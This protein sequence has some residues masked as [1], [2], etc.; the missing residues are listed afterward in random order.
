VTER[1]TTFVT[2]T[3]G[4]GQL[5][6]TQIDEPVRD[7]TWVENGILTVRSSSA[8]VTLPVSNL[9]YFTSDGAPAPWYAVAIT[10][11]ALEYN[12][13]TYV[14]YQNHHEAGDQL[15]TK[16]VALT[17]STG[18]WS[19]GYGITE[20]GV[21]ADSHGVP[22]SAVNADGRLVTAGKGH[23]SN[24]QLDVSTNVEDIR[25]WT[26]PV[27]LTG[28]YAYPHLVL[29][30]DDT[31]L[32]LLR[33]RFLAGTG[34]FTTGAMVLVY[35][36]ITFSGATA[37]PGSEVTVADFGDNSRWY[38]GNCILHDG[39][40]WQ[41]AARSD[42]GDGFRR[43]VYLYAVDTAN[44][45]LVA[46]D[47]TTRSFPVSAADME[48]VFKIHDS[49]DTLTQ[50]IPAMVV[51]D[52]GRWH[53]VYSEGSIG[54]DDIPIYHMYADTFGGA[55]STPAQIGD[56][57]LSA[58][59]DSPTILKSA[60]G[61][62]LYHSN[63]PE[64]V[65]TFA[66]GGNIYRR[67]LAD[68]STTWGDEE[69]VCEMDTTR[70]PLNAPAQVFNSSSAGPRVIW[71]EQALADDTSETAPPKRMY[72]MGDTQ[73]FPKP[74][75]IL[76]GAVTLNGWEF[77][78]T[79]ATMYSDDPGV[80]PAVVDGTVRIV[81][82]T[83]GNGRHFQSMSMTEHG[84]LRTDGFVN[85]LDLGDTTPFTYFQT[86]SFNHQSGNSF[87]GVIAGR[88][89]MATLASTDVL[90]VDSGSSSG[91][92]LVRFFYDSTGTLSFSPIQAAG[93]Q[94]NIADVR[95]TPYA[96]DFVIGGYMNAGAGELYVDDSGV[97][98]ASNGSVGTLDST[99][100]PARLGCGTVSDGSAA[101]WMA[102][103]LYYGAWQVGTLSASDRQ[104]LMGRALA[105]IPR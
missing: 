83:S 1:D 39:L 18:E 21:A 52:D 64:T 13:K 28:A 49:G 35:R 53:L 40:V 15:I 98:V 43:D 77:D 60:G 2:E 104:A 87:F 103:R 76:P 91:N 45:R 69:L 100:M 99:N 31:M 72:A 47:G 61:V 9:D 92:R 93:S 65:E 96:T 62:H 10:P 55:W 24:N 59:G 17:H 90:A 22:S 19:K 73:T 97:A 56:A 36:I 41:C 74:A 71:S 82:D 85:W 86:E 70:W 29:L 81:N 34:G 79:A 101:R 30:P 44:T 68:G 14:F 84:T 16:V 54:G 32:C 42:L 75:L 50:Q 58:T 6:V 63:D 66:R 46:W 20:E 11:N 89:W 78:P 8:P 7:I 48:S 95:T 25:T 23:N 38:Q 33:K 26:G 88:V 12:G 3:N 27:T 80:T 5:S 94:I 51:D 105:R 4:R 67:F 57:V 102:G 37:T